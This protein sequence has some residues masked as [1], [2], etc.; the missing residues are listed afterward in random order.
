MLVVKVNDGLNLLSV[1]IEHRCAKTRFGVTSTA[2]AG[3][4]AVKE[5]F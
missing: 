3:K 2:G 4:T 5:S 1:R